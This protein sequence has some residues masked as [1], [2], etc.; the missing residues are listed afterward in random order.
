MG[1]PEQYQSDVK[2]ILKRRHVNGGD[3]WATADNRLGVGSPFSTLQCALILIDLGM[4]PTDSVLASTAE[5]IMASRREDGRFRLAPKGAIYPCHTAT[6]ARI[7]CR[8]GYASDERL[9]KTFNYFFEIQHKDGGWRCNKNSFGKGPETEF[10]N[11]GPTLEALDAFRF[12]KFLNRDARLEDAIEFLL[13]HWQTRT[14][15]GPCY[16][17]IGTLFMKIEYPFFRYNLF[18]YVYVLSFFDKAKADRR[19]LEAL[20]ILRSKL[21]N[22]KI[23]VENP[24]RKLAD[25]SFCRKGEPSEIAT[26]RYDE[27]LRNIEN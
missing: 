16:F 14:P 8:L 12:S 21:S 6:A 11:P 23:V 27:I 17:G 9:E 4:E 7:M 20:D 22:N 13:R 5:L 15:L 26:K 2:E 24:N 25:F 18:F 1:I 10:S 19:F 3:L